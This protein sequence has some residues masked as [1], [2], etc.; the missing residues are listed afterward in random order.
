[1]MLAQDGLLIAHAKRDQNL[2][3]LDVAISGKIMQANQL[4]MITTGQGRPTHLV[5]RIKKVRIWHRRFGHASN[6]QVIRALKLVTGMGD[7]GATY[8]PT[9]IYNDSQA[10]DEEETTNVSTNSLTLTYQAS[11]ISSLTET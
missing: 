9:E 11:N 5:S 7:F 3:V 6:A 1:M 8:D 10:S 2:F 4:A